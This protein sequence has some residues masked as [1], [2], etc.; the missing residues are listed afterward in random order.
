LTQKA[1][2]LGLKTFFSQSSP[3]TK[4]ELAPLLEEVQRQMQSGR[5]FH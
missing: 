5:S 4:A 2:T 3:E 1:Q